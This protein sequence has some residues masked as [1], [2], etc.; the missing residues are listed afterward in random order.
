MTKQNQTAEAKSERKRWPP[1][2]RTIVGKLAGDLTG[3]V[4][5]PA[6][7]TAAGTIQA[8]AAQLSDRQLQGA[9]RRA[10]GAHIGRMQGNGHLQRVVSFGKR[11]RAATTGAP[12][13]VQMRPGRRRRGAHPGGR[14][15]GHIQ[16]A[17]TNYYTVSGATLH[18]IVGQL[19]HF[20]GY[21]SETNAPITIRGRVT[22]QHVGNVYQVRV[23]WVISGATVGLP[24]WTNY[25]TAC[26]AAQHEWD[27][28]MGQARQHEQQAHV[29][30]ARTFV[31]NLGEEDTVI[32]GSTVAD[33]QANLAAKQQELAGR[34]QT[35]HDSC[36]HGIS[37]DA[38]LHPDRGRCSE[39]E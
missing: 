7:L 20:G 33:L 17:T 36:D 5:L 15:S 3:P 31:R 18:D 37:I 39:E 35:I 14:G 6:E 12:A 28:F 25:N 27:R 30:A 4:A 23:Q 2:G 22:P 32:T 24:R 26:S 9:Q 13:T 16:H 1:V 21:A 11:A 29:D 10:L 38:T 19:S 8:Q 34:L